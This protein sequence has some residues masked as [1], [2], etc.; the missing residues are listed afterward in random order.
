MTALGQLPESTYCDDSPG[1]GRLTSEKGNLPLVAMTVVADITALLAATSV[2]QTFRNPH[3]GPIEATYIFPLPDRAAVTDFSVTIG[4]RRLTGVLEERQV[5]RDAFDL[6]VAAGKRAALLEEDRPDVFTTRVGNLAPGEEAT[7]E[8]TLAGPVAW[9]YGEATLRIPL[10]VAPRYIPGPPLD[11]GAGAGQGTALDTDAVPD[12][13][14]ITPPRLVP[15]SANP[16]RLSV[17]VHLDPAGMAVS[18]LR[19]SLH[20]VIVAG[21]LPGKVTV[22]L[23]PG[24]TAAATMRPRAR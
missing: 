18:D 22:E 4:G 3:D 23:A 15:G 24:A 11:G 21:D 12:A 19:S 17:T 5:A 6:A 20:S 16:V 7:V 13:S 14:R 1:A 8:L 10:V 2:R 9:E